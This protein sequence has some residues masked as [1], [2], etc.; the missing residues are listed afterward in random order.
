MKRAQVLG[1]GSSLSSKLTFDSSIW[2]RRASCINSMSLSPLSL[3]KGPK[4]LT[5][6]ICVKSLLEHLTHSMCSINLQA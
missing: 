1:L 3:R 2:M 5:G 6:V 4:Y